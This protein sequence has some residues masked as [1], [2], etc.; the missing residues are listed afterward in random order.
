MTAATAALDDRRRKGRRT[1]KESRKI[2]QLE[3]ELNRK[4]KALAE[5]AALLILKKKVQSIWG[6]EEGSPSGRKGS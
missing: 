3:K 2:R 5:A 6:G 4:E 1:T